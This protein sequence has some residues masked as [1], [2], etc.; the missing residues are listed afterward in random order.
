MNRHSMHGIS[1]IEVLVTISLIG[2][3]SGLAVN[4]FFS[5]T[6]SA[7]NAVAVTDYRNIKVAVIDLTGAQ[8]G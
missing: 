6:G 3:L 8:D 7:K 4:N 5:Y 2:V 1:L